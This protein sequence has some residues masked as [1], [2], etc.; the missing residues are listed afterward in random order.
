MLCH[1]ATMVQVVVFLALVAALVW[2]VLSNMNNWADWVVFGVIVL[3]TIGAAIAI[4]PRR[5]PTK[6]RTFIR[7]S[8][9]PPR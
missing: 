5:Y 2:A 1:R 4:Y 6:K 7:H 9:Q 8:D 3:T